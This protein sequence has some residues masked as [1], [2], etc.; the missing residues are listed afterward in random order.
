MLISVYIISKIS[1]ISMGRGNLRI[2]MS[3]FWA[4]PSPTF[5]YKTIEGSNFPS[6]TFEHKSDYLP[7]RFVDHGLLSRGNFSVATTEH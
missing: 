3:V 2:P 7:R 1:Q 4:G 5:I 6:K